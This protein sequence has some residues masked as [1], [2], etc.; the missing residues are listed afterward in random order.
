MLLHE[1]SPVRPGREYDTT[2]PAPTACRRRQPARRHVG[3]PTLT[4]LGYENIGDGFCNPVK[5]LQARRTYGPEG[6][7]NALIHG[8]HGMTEHTN[9]LRHEGRLPG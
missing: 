3:V 7:F 8:M 6:T 1:V 2:V 5:K 4:D 9:A